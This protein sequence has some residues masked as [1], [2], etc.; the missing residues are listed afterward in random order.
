[1]L[2]LDDWALITVLFG[3][4]ESQDSLSANELD[5]DHMRTVYAAFFP[6]FIPPK[7]YEFLGIKVDALTV[8]SFFGASA[9]AVAQSRQI[10]IANH[11]VH[12]LYIQRRSESMCR[13]FAEADY[14]F[15]DG[16]W[17]VYL[18]QLFKQPLLRENRIPPLDWHDQFFRMAERSGWRL[19][20]EAPPRFARGSSNI[21]DL[22]MQC[23]LRSITMATSRH[24]LVRSIMRGC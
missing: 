14:V 16:M 6:G 23:C 5:P 22:S 19:L 8:K 15:A 12:S 10:V 9:A 4:L 7:R 3:M 18:A 13:F 17:I 20:L 21:F 24:G 11:N 2:S 1:M